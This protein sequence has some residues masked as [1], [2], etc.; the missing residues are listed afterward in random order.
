M[1]SRGTTHTSI[2]NRNEELCDTPA[3][4]G[5]GPPEAG[6]QTSF[7]LHVIVAER[8]SPEDE[9]RTGERWSLRVEYSHGDVGRVDYV[10]GFNALYWDE[11]CSQD[12]PA[13]AIVAELMFEQNR[14]FHVGAFEVQ[15]VN[16]EAGLKS[17]RNAEEFLAQIKAVR[18]TCL[19]IPPI[20][21]LDHGRPA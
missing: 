2:S 14:D 20:N 13:T 10:A 1:R 12:F 6:G 3:R 11:A 9:V 17:S 4:G 19:H 5:E 18:I 16:P 21:K 15:L 7:K 8:R